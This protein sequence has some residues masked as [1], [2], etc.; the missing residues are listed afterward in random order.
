MK[1]K[2]LFSQTD[3]EEVLT[4]IKLHY[5][6][7][8]LEDFRCLYKTLSEMSPKENTNDM[9]IIINAFIVCDEDDIWVEDFN[10]GDDSLYYDVSAFSKNEDIVYSIVSSDYASFLGYYV[11]DSILSKLSAPSILAH[12]LWEITAYSFE[13]KV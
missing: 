9:T 2:E 3:V 10:D 1:M 7:A 11:D 8:S 4:H 13:D 6:E 5:E 12:C